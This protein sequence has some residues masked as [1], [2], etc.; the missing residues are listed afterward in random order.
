M[1]TELMARTIILFQPVSQALD[2]MTTY[3][4][5]SVWNDATLT[6]ERNPVMRWLWLAVG[7][8][9]VLVLKIALGIIAALALYYVYRRQLGRGVLKPVYWVVAGGSLCGLMILVLAM[10]GATIILGIVGR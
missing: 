6:M 1:N 4:G 3:L 9:S 2:V 7:P 10:N 5:I 8:L